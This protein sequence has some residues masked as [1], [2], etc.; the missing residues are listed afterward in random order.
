MHFLLGTSCLGN[1][2]LGPANADNEC[3]HVPLYPR[4]K[5]VVIDVFGV[6]E[7]K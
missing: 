4:G 3:E 1:I 2:T 7:V 5:T 6:Q